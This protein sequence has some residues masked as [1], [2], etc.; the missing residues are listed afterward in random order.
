MGHPYSVYTNRQKVTDEV[1]VGFDTVTLHVLSA[2]LAALPYADLVDLVGTLP[3]G[4]PYTKSGGRGG[5]WRRRADGLVLTVS[6]PRVVHG[7]NAQPLSPA[8]VETAL[9]VIARALGVDL[10][11]VLGAR[12][13]RLDVAGDIALAC[14]VSEYQQRLAYVARAHRQQYSPTSVAFINKSRQLAFYDKPAQL[15]ETKQEVPEAMAGKHVMRYELRLLRGLTGLFGNPLVASDLADL[16]VYQRAVVLWRDRYETVQTQS[17][18]ALGE[19]RTVPALVHGLAAEQV[20]HVGAP[21]V[22][23]AVDALHAD[24][25][26]TTDMRRKQRRC[27]LELATGTTAPEDLTVELHAAVHAAARRA[28]TSL[29]P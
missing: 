19:P 21:A 6:L 15:R 10:D 12:V 2:A 14:R 1:P 3:W 17:A 9:V 4:G 18:P 28:H 27:V 26:T 5:W 29:I 25:L 20:A 11:V 13:Y 24:G 22:I 7:T 23:A 16:A 8:L